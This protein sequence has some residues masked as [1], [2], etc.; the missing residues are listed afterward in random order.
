MRCAQCGSSIRHEP[1]WSNGMAFCSL[2]CT[3]ENALVADDGFTEEA[4]ASELHTL[5][6]AD[7]DDDC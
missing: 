3:E 2:E 5:F 1:F 4:H 7:D 6:G